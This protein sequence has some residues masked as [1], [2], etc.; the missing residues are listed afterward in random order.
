[1]LETFA[2]TMVKVT[3]VSNG[4][5]S[6]RSF[7]SNNPQ[8]SSACSLTLESSFP[9]NSLATAWQQGNS[10]SFWQL[11]ISS[12]LATSFWSASLYKKVHLILN[13]Y[14]IPSFPLAWNN[15]VIILLFVWTMLFFIWLI[16]RYY[17]VCN[18]LVKLL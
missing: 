12:R 14:F 6:C 10:L 13:L 3:L 11:E 18:W 1:M 9:S 7:W 2:P 5:K 16:K 4:I 15:G 8:S 17:S